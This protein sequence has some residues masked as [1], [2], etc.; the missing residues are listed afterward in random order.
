M[1]QFLF[2]SLFV[3]F[4]IGDPQS[5]YSKARAFIVVVV[6]FLLG[7]FLKQVFL[8]VKTDFSSSFCDL[9]ANECFNG[10]YHRIPLTSRCLLVFV[11]SLDQWRLSIFYV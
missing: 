4:F 1:G 8:A 9:Q 5:S 11:T 3:S 10:L 7:T 6:V 2:F